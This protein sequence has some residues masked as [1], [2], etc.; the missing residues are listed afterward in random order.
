MGPRVAVAAGVAG[1]LAAGSLVVGA[2]LPWLTGGLAVA[3]V[4][5]LRLARS[6]G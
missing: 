6:R 3:A 2:S 1:A 4:V 5:A